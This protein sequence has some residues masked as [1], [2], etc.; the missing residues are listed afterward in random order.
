MPVHD[1]SPPARQESFRILRDY[2]R[3]KDAQV[4]H[5]F[6]RVFTDDAIFIATHAVE[7]PVSGSEPTV[8]LEAVTTLFREMGRQCENIVTVVPSETVRESAGLVTSDWVVAL[9]LR[10]GAPGFVGWGTYQ[11]TLAA[12]G[13]RAVQLAVHF[14]GKVALNADLATPVL[15]VLVDQ[16]HPF[17]STTDLKQASSEVPELMPLVRWLKR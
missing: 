15:D 3:A 1:S 9:T 16:S 13:T 12:C 8:G 17:C 7:S 4:P 10:N 14:A 2:L 5:L 6:A 11:W